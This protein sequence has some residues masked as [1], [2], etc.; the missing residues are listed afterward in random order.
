MSALQKFSLLGSTGSIGTQSLE[1]IQE[2]PEQFELVALAA[3]EAC[4][5][6]SAA[7]SVLRSCRLKGLQTTL[8]VIDVCQLT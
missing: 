4:G 1:I 7:W 8:R 5:V 3:G 6:P 2:H